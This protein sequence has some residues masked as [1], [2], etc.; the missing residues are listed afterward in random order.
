VR[1]AAALLAVL[2]ALV[3]AFPAVAGDAAL[4]DE[5]LALAPLDTRPKVAKGDYDGVEFTLI[6]TG[7]LTIEYAAGT[8][9]TYDALYCFEG[10]GS[11]PE[12]RSPI[13]MFVPGNQPIPSTYGGL[14][15]WNAIGTPPYSSSHR[16][17]L[18]PFNTA[19]TDLFEKM[20]FEIARS[21]RDCRDCRFRGAFNVRIVSGA[22]PKTAGN[23]RVEFTVRASGRPSLPIQ[24]AGP[25]PATARLRG[26]GH[27]TFPIRRGAARLT[28]NETKGS[29]TL[30][31]GARSLKLGI[32]SGTTYF[33]GTK[34]LVLLLKVNESN[35]P[36]CEASGLLTGARAATLTLLPVSFDPDLGTT[37]FV[38][39]PVKKTLVGFGPFRLEV[40]PCKGYGFG[41]RG[42][43]GAAV[44]I[45][46]RETKLP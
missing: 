7:T 26:S 27:A 33:P 39:V 2:G 36:D 38:G 34:R 8:S 11:E 3:V 9:V 5:S 13:T 21:Y 10:C 15:D 46:L 43:A 35:D 24:G 1:G 17:E 40:T 37:I 42:G 32:I 14:W 18:G 20:Q 23:L 30:S 4:T 16:Y 44:R 28:A 6:V 25:T 19:Q 31:A 29:V 41:W 45:L 12:N 22:K